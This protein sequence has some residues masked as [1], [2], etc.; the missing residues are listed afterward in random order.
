MA[1]SDVARLPK[2]L[3]ARGRQELAVRRLRRRL[4]IA[5]RN[6]LVS[7]GLAYGRWTVPATLDEQS[8][9]YLAGIG[10]DITFDLSLI[11]RFGCT[12]HAFDPVPESID[13]ARIATRAE[14]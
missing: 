10:R 9:A 7:F 1:A 13:F 5:S 12:V 2:R 8:V 6:D 3:A 4:E 14:P 11:A